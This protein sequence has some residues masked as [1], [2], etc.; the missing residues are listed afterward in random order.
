MEEVVSGE[1]RRGPERRH[2]RPREPL[3]ERLLYARPHRRPLTSPSR[4]EAG[5][6]LF[7]VFGFRGEITPGQVSLTPKPSPQSWEIGV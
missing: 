3:T 4:G 6:E 1:L 5:T 7:P 2:F